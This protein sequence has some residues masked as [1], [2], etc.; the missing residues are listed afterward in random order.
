MDCTNI[1]YTGLDVY[2]KRLIKMAIEL[3]GIR[4]GCSLRKNNAMKHHSLG[5][6]VNSV[7]ASHRNQVQSNNWN[8]E[9]IDE[10]RNYKL[11]SLLDFKSI[12]ITIYLVANCRLTKRDKFC[13]NNMLDE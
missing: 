13:R 9:A 4:H 11:V 2:L 5:N 10:E 6:L 1:L 7:S 8:L 3:A 12:S